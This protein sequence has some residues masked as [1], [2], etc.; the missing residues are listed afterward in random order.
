MS[1]RSRF[2]GFVHA[3]R[4]LLLNNNFTQTLLLVSWVLVL[5]QH[6]VIPSSS[7]NFSR[8]CYGLLL[9]LYK[10]ASCAIVLTGGKLVQVA[11][12]VIWQFFFVPR[13]AQLCKE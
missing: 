8:P 4:L 7:R 2:F 11:C 10:L 12:V 5:G 13:A 3:I 9:C 6:L 1:T